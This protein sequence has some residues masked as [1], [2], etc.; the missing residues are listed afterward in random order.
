MSKIIKLKESDLKLM[1]EQ[2]INQAV[3]NSNVTAIQ[4]ALKSLGQPYAGL[5]GT[6]GPNHDGVDGV[7]GK[8]TRNAVREYQKANGIRPTGYVGKVTAPK[9]G[10]SPMGNAGSS[11]TTSKLN[12][13]PNF[14]KNAALRGTVAQQDNTRI[15][16]NPIQNVKGLAVSKYANKD[17]LSKLPLDKIN[18]SKGGAIGKAPNNVP[19]CA[20]FVNM[21]SDKFS[22]AGDAWLAHDNDSLG[23]RKWDAFGNLKPETIKKIENEWLKINNAGG[24]QEGGQFNDE[25]RNLVSTLVPKTPP[26]PLKID[27]VV[28]IYYPPSDHHEEAFY[29]AGM[30]Y[31]TNVN[32]KITPGKTIGGGQGWGMN[33]HLGIV[34]AVKDGVPIILHNVHGT[35]F[36]D[37]V[38]KLYKGGR[39]AWVK[40]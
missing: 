34:G 22:F 31:F 2:A 29:K 7:Y 9:L 38:D 15:N 11:S 18:P 20:K 5:L 3:R 25:V 19:D 26:I 33:T 10:V 8:N 17:V 21:F 30:P 14:A 13:D 16:Q 35:V 40:A 24:G 1:V 27:D 4:N 28:G 37:P 39:V 12:I 32:G 6:T 36:A 23:K